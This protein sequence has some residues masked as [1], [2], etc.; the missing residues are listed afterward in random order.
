MYYIRLLFA[1]N[2]TVAYIIAIIGGISNS[3]L[4]ASNF[5][6][7][8]EIFPQSSS[9]AALMSKFAINLGQF[10]LPVAILLGGFVGVPFRVV[11]MSTGI[12]YLVLATLLAFLPYPKQVQK[13]ANNEKNSNNSVQKSFSLGTI[14]LVFMGFTTTA[15]F[16]LWINTYQELAKSYGIAQP[17]T[18]Q[19]VYAIGASIAVLFNSFILKK[20]IKEL[21]ILI[22]YPL[23]SAASLLLAYAINAPWILYVTSLCVGFFAANGLYQLTSAVLGNLYPTMKATTQSWA[24]LFSAFAQFGIISMAAWITAIA[25]NAA[26]KYILL[27]NVANMVLSTALA[28]LV[29]RDSKNH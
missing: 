25:G 1:P 6:T 26:P 9:A 5:P 2:Q 13:T 12:V 24:G 10:F 19:S 17:S 27:L 4:N 20:G 11:F 3:F 21:D 7:L 8:M 14:C 15:A 28:L 22:Y 23:I 29:K 18:L 16:L